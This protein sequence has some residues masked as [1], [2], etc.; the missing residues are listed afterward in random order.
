M[1]NKTKVSKRVTS[2]AVM[3]FAIIVSACIVAFTWRNNIKS[4]QTIG[5]T[6]SAKRTIVSD[7]GI[8]RGSIQINAVNPNDGY[9][10]V[11]NQMPVVIKYLNEAGIKKDQIERFPITSFAN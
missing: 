9:V 4:Q 2:S 6:G 10:Q 8:L 5:V 1:V 7:I 3:A 11:K